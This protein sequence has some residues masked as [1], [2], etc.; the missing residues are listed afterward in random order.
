MIGLAAA[1]I[2]PALSWLAQRLERYAIR[3]PLVVTPLAGLTVAALAIAYAQATGKESGQ[4]LFSGQTALPYL[5]HHGAT[6]TVG[7]AGACVYG[8]Q[9]AGL[10]R[11][12]QQFP[13]RA[14]VPGDVHRRGRRHR[15]V[16]PARAAAGSRAWPWAYQALDVSG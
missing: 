7:R 1:V 5:I 16:P 6:Y 12:A 3:W 11:L 14:G 15:S 4:V 10:Q 13:R 9:G 2:G 8:M